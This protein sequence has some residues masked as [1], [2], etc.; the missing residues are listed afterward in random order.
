MRFLCLALLVATGGVARA[1]HPIEVGGSLGFHIFG[2]SSELGSFDDDPF[3]D[4]PGPAPLIAA[5]G[6]IKIIPRLAAD[7]ELGYMASGAR[8]GMGSYKTVFYRA[9]LEFFPFLKPIQK[10]T[11][12]VAL[13][14]GAESTYPSGNMNLFNDTDEMMHL[15]IGAQYALTPRFGLRL[16]VRLLLPPARHGSGIT[17]DFAML[18]GV[19][20]RL[21]G[22]HHVVNNSVL[23]PE[24]EPTITVNPE[25]RD[26]DGDGLNDAVDKCPNLMET[27]NGYQDE[28]GC[29][30]EV[31][32]DLAKLNGPIVG[33][34]FEQGSASIKHSSYK[35]LDAV[36]AVLNKYPGTVFEIAGY[37]DDQGKADDNVKLS[38]AR[39]D[40]VKQY[41]VKGGV[42]AGRLNA[43]GR[44]PANPIA[45]NKTSAGKAKNRR[46]ELK[47]V[48]P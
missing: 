7:L 13:G 31:P 39:A 28:D 12:Y 9:E 30:D 8:N 19:Y 25:D 43:V 15:G 24:K 6:S 34:E 45:D 46:V 10:I 21:G 23:H 47:L 4:A 42:G 29:P 48:T 18:A 22:G 32:D 33:L 3:N 5:R 20:V 16:D 36:V 17:E 27:K 41:L 44:G 35:S 40:A 1:D 26:S 2:A 14:Y 37:T 11:P 38:G